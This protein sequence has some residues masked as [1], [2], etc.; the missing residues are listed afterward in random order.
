MNTTR[1]QSR[2]VT[3]FPPGQPLYAVYYDPETDSIGTDP[4][5]AL[6]FW[7][8]IL[9][10]NGEEDRTVEIRPVPFSC[11]HLSEESQI[12]RSNNFLGLSLEPHP[13]RTTFESGIRQYRKH[14]GINGEG[15]AKRTKSSIEKKGKSVA[16][17]K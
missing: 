3:A 11:D 13:D 8:H 1:Y 17:S 14:H 15:E 4:I 16:N 6:T 9:I 12:E 10:E 5:I 7:E 2:L